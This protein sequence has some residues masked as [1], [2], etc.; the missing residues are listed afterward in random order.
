MMITPAAERCGKPAGF[1]KGLWESRQRFP[2]SRR[3]SAAGGS[4]PEI[5]PSFVSKSLT[6]SGGAPIAG[7]HGSSP[8]RNHRRPTLRPRVRRPGSSDPQDHGSSPPDCSRAGG[9]RAQGFGYGLGA[10]LRSRIACAILPEPRLRGPPVHLGPSRGAFFGMTKPS[11]H[12]VL[13]HGR[14]SGSGCGPILHTTHLC[15]AAQPMVSAFGTML[16]SISPDQVQKS[17]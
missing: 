3:L 7:T 10:D 4:A 17:Q 13:T 8:W 12:A 16:E 1:S 14:T 5:R 11:R 6:R 9:G 15:E 2:W